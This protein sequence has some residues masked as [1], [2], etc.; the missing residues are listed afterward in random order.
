MC[1]DNTAPF[2]T[3]PPCRALDCEYLPAIEGE[4]MGFKNIFN[5]RVTDHQEAAA[6]QMQQQRQA[7]VI[8]Q[9]I[10]AEV[11]PKLKALAG[12]VFEAMSAAKWPSIPVD[13][14]TEAGLRAYALGRF[15]TGFSGS[16]SGNA[17]AVVDSQGRLA[18]V[19]GVKILGQWPD[20]TAISTRPLNEAYEKL[21]SEVQRSD[22][23][24]PTR[25]TITTEGTL[26]H[27]TWYHDAHDQPV[28]TYAPLEEYLANL[29]AMTL[30]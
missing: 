24:V 20:Q 8:R 11:E 18:L 21:L 3:V 30:K 12:E 9:G 27:C 10:Q 1:A 15:H 13:G 25:L 22:G 19:H 26:M 23:P 17:D 6:A 28:Y 2:T 5:K 14:G 16:T 7:A 29:A 4:A